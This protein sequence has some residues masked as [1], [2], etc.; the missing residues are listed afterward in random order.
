MSRVIDLVPSLVTAPAV[1]P[2]DATYAKLHIKALSTAEDTLIATWIPG[3]RQYLEE[4]TGRQFITAIWEVWLDAFPTCPSRIEL[5]RPPLQ[6]VL[7]VLYVNG[8]GDLVPFS[9]G[10][11]P[12]TLY[13]TWTAPQGPFARRGW[14][15]PASGQ[16]W[17]TP[18]GV[19]PGAVRIQFAAGY[20]DLGAD[21]PEALRQAL[22]FL[23]GSFDQFRSESHL[24]ER[25]GTLERLPFGVQALLDGFKYSALP[26]V[27]HR[28]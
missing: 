19:E 5:P 8:D 20:G 4:Q 28:T 12:E 10:A 27:V 26:S 24:T 17:P 25:G 18:R 3:A 15:E 11:S 16:S 14:I 21:V 2:I 22:A 9:D 6:N 7:S 13:Y 23:V 1:E